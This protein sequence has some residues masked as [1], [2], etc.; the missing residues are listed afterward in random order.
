MYTTR[1]MMTVGVLR[2][3]VK[4]RNV[5]VGIVELVGELKNEKNAPVMATQL[6]AISILKR[7]RKGNI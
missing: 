3:W 2:G 5:N 7:G 6:N 1:P 4:W